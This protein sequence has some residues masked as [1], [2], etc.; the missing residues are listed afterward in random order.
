[1]RQC[2]YRCGRKG[3]TRDHVIPRSRGGVRVWV[4]A[5]QACNQERGT[6]PYPEYATAR[7]VPVEDVV[8]TMLS[9]MRAFIDHHDGTPVPWQDEHAFDRL[10]A[11]EHEW[12]YPWPLTGGR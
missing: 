11:T 12:V 2:H 8:R 6:I 9:A 1:M 10:E 7:G 3:N 4:N 5:C